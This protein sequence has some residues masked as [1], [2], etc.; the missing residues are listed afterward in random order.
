[1]N[2]AL[3]LFA[4]AAPQGGSQPQ[5]GNP[6]AMFLPMII[7]FAIFY[8]MLIRPQQRREKER[9][10]L[11]SEI[12]SGD[13]VM[14]SGGILGIVSNVKDSTF[15]VKVADNVKLEVARGAVMKVID[16]DDKITT[17]DGK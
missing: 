3:I 13:K 5:G 12:K 2:E 10:K 7:I 17:E 11:I 16:K 4:M 1:M 15:T 14:F 6:L 9:T 8:F